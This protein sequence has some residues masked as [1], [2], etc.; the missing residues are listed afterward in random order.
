MFIDFPPKSGETEPTPAE[1]ITSINAELSAIDTEEAHIPAELRKR[2]EQQMLQGGVIGTEDKN[3]SRIEPLRPEEMGGFEKFRSSYD[4]AIDL[5]GEKREAARA[6]EAQWRAAGLEAIRE[7]L[8]EIERQNVLRNI[9]TD[10]GYRD[11]LLK[12]RMVNESY[13]GTDKEER[14]VLDRIFSA[15]APVEMGFPKEIAR[16]EALAELQKQAEVAA[17]ASE[18]ARKAAEVPVPGL[19]REQIVKT[20]LAY[21]DAELPEE[22]KKQTLE[23]SRSSE[24]ANRYAESV[25]RAGA[26]GGIESVRKVAAEIRDT[27]LSEATRLGIPVTPYGQSASWAMWDIGKQYHFFSHPDENNPEYEIGNPLESEEKREEIL[28]RHLG[29]EAYEAFQNDPAYKVRVMGSPEYRKVESL[30]TKP[31]KTSHGTL[32]SKDLAELGKLLRE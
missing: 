8:I 7:R 25:A 31:P 28:N 13:D 27:M 22:L 26:I 24:S 15:D 12:G 21:Q 11:R 30:F 4:R 23:W 2:Y 16:K 5:Q 1:R 17:A 32:N 18:A 9:R 3:Y 20:D 29:W 14:E 6:L 10:P 19:I